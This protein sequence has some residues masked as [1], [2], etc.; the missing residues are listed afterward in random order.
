M[1]ASATEGTGSGSRPRIRSWMSRVISSA[2]RSASS[3]RYRAGSVRAGFQ[4]L[5]RAEPER[6]LVLDAD[7]PTDEITRDIQ[8]RIRGML[9]DPVPSVAEAATGDFP[10]IK[11]EVR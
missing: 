9:P 3:T 4:A 10:A 1:A 2:G 7:Q 5:A 8:E 11:E 6:Y